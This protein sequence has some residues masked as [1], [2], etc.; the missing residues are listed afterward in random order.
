G[1][2][3]ANTRKIN[4]GY[5]SVFLK[6]GFDVVVLDYPLN[7]GRQEIMEQIRVLSKQ[8]SF[9]SEHAREFD[10]DPEHFFLTGDSAGGHFAL[11]L[12]EMICDPEIA[13]S[14]ELD[15]AGFSCRAVSVSC[16]VYDLEKL[17]RESPLTKKGMPELYGPSWNDAAYVRAI[18]P[19]TYIS[20]LTMPVF[21]NTCRNDFLLEHS[22][23]LAKDLT[24]A[25]H[26]PEYLYL[27][28]KNKEVIH[29][30]NVNN[31]SLKESKQVNREMMEI[32]LMHAT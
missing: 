15:L 12:S 32:F 5:A 31:I 3:I 2:Y 17:I 22:Q 1:A 4:Y 29:V 26:K 8:L 24:E 19:G 6:E 20:S 14:L 7:D 16:P 23:L 10:L 18:S 11:L 30:H 21:I 25:G 28:E 27:D 9:L 13:K